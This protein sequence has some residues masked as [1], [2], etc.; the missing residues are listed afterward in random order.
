MRT[1]PYLLALADRF[2]EAA[3]VG[4]KALAGDKPLGAR[5]DRSRPQLG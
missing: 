2:E 5:T 1:N 3:K 4:D